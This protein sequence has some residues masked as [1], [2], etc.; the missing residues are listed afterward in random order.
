VLSL[1]LL[2]TFLIIF[3]AA[4]VITFISLVI[5]VTRGQSGMRLRCTA[6]NHCKKKQV[7]S[8]KAKP[9]YVSTYCHLLQKE[10]KPDSRC[11]VPDKSKAMFEG[12]G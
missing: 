11:I 4:I 10:L 1:S 6:C 8:G 5:L 2:V 7:K 9:T 3:G 12:K